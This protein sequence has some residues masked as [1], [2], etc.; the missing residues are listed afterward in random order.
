M[1][2]NIS[3][4]FGSIALQHIFKWCFKYLGNIIPNNCTS[5]DSQKGY[6]NVYV[7]SPNLMIM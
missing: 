5:K 3:E 7:I 1:N 2:G 6:I 4:R